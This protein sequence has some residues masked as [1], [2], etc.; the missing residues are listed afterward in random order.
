MTGGVVSLVV[1]PLEDAELTEASFDLAV[2]ASSFHWVDP[3]IGLRKVRRLLATRALYATFSPIARL[4]DSE[5]ES[6]LDAT[7]EVS[8]RE[9]GGV[10]ERPMLTPLYM[11]RRPE[12]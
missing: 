11:A 8:E 10:V 4:G 3:E 2:A 5:R 7:S 9:F 6:L 1:A 12:S